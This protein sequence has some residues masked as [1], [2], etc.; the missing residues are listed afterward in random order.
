[1][2]RRGVWFWLGW[3]CLVGAVTG[4]LDDQITPGLQFLLMGAAILAF[5]R[6]AERIRQAHR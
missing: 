6:N 4:I 3:L 5:S 2:D 1:M